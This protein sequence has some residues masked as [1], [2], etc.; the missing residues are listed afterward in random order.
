MAE[1]LETIIKLLIFRLA[2][3]A[4]KRFGFWGAIALAAGFLGALCLAV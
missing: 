3:E 2:Q 4:S 1:W